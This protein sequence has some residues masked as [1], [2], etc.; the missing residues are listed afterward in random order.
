MS[1]WT[2]EKKDTYDECVESDWFYQTLKNLSHIL[3]FPIS[4]RNGKRTIFST[5]EIKDKIE[6]KII[7]DDKFS[8]TC[9]FPNK[10]DVHSQKISE[11]FCSLLKTILA[12]RFNTEF[13]INSLSG[14]ILDKYEELNLLFD[15]SQSLGTHLSP[16][17]IFNVILEKVEIAL[18]VD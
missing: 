18:D 16:Q 5:G 11:K 7:F 17:R 13:E 9:E 3:S 8:L 10:K 15:F 2:F 6:K 14:E 4:I 12:D 1:D